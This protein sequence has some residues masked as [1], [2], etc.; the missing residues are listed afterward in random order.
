M[1][2]IILSLICSAPLMAAELH[3]GPGQ[4]H[5]TVTAAVEAASPGDVIKVHSGVYREGNLRIAKP[6]TLEGIGFPV[7]DGGQ[8]HEMLSITAPDVRVT[9]FEFRDS[10]RS[11]MT[12]LAGVKIIETTRVTLEG[13]RFR[14][15]H[16]GIHITRSTDCRISGNDILGA[17][18]REQNTGNGI[19]LWHCARATI[20]GNTVRGQ[21]DGIYL[22]FTTESLL[23]D[24]MVE[25]NLRY[26]LH[27]MF[28]HG[29]AYH[30]NSFQSNGAGVAVMYSRDVEMSRNYFGLNWGA[31][32]YGLLLKEMT[33]G[34]ITGNTFER[35]TTA[36]TFDGSNRMTVEGNE[37]RENGRAIQINASS[38]TN[39]F[40]KNN[41]SGNAFDIA[42]SGELG[43]NRLEANYW[44][45]YEG[46]DLRRDGTGDVPY[47][48]VSLYAVMVDRVPPSVLLLRSPIVHVLDQ[49]EKAFPS[50]T[51]ET[52][53]DD[54]PSM[55]PHSLETF[56]PAP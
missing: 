55:R 49:A 31:A 5:A 7:L 40:S 51:P 38:S 41:F 33:S 2:R 16:F 48:P 19:H 11:S 4:P 36:L 24:N 12:D 15:C 25:K 35:N 29:N 20:T 21:R 8:K 27:F 3:V 13:N 9:G 6:L 39:V 50:I 32:S 28:S 53:K 56:R 17:I 45:K 34:R 43:D 22:E 54:A 14:D 30:R 47:R 18:D 10:G 52:V 46:Y 37:F 23:E 42:A 1:R 44:D 26:G